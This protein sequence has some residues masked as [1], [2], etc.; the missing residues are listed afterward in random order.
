[1]GTETGKG[2]GTAREQKY[3]RKTGCGEPWRQ[4]EPKGSGDVQF[5]SGI[6][7]GTSSTNTVCHPDR[8][9]LL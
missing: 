4:Q 3:D 7:D 6:D 2:R 1:M 8:Y 5:V 9:Q